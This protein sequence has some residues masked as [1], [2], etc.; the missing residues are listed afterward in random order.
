ME[1]RIT[2]QTARMRKKMAAEEISALVA[3]FFDDI[4][5]CAYET[6]RTGVRSFIYKVVEQVLLNLLRRE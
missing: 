4:L 5:Q 2:A 6:E 3:E 1:E